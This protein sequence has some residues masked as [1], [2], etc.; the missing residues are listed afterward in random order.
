MFQNGGLYL[1][2]NEYYVNIADG[3]GDSNEIT[4]EAVDEIIFR[5]KDNQSVACINT[6]S[7]SK[8]CFEPVSHDIVLKKLNNVNA[9]KATGHDSM[10]CAI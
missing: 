6:K 4:D 2:L 5:H 8:S 7:F 1:I 9:K 10:P 3:I